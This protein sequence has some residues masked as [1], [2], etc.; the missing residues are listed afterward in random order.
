MEEFAERLRALE[1]DIER[2]KAYKA[3]ID[4]MGKYQVYHHPITAPGKKNIFAFSMPDVCIDGVTRRIGKDAIM[5]L[6]KLLTTSPVNG[7]MWNHQIDTPIVEVAG[8]CQTARGLFSSIATEV[9]RDIIGD[10]KQ[11]AFWSCG[12]YTVDFIKENGEWKIWHM[13]RWQLFKTDFYKSWTDDM[14]GHTT[15]WAGQKDVE[16]MVAGSKGGEALPKLFTEGYKPEKVMPCVPWFPEPYDT[17]HDGDEDWV[18]GPY[19]EFYLD[20]LPDEELYEYEEFDK[21]T[22]VHMRKE[23]MKF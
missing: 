13:R 6:Q 16:K 21:C 2:Q 14:D 18:Y 20:P 23:Y 22:L 15:P 4:L 17:W 12:K 3:C 10:G 5:D 9:N 7:V 1:L 11:H 19:K 8:D